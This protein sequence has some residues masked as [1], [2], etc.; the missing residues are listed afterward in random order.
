MDETLTPVDFEAFSEAL[1][2][3][4]LETVEQ[5]PTSPERHITFRTD[6]GP[7][8]HVAVESTDPDARLV[9]T[10]VEES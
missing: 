10:R 1:E 6:G 9:F 3:H 7:A 2:R 5:A 4:G 8:F